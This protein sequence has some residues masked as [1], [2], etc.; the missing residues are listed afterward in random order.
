MYSK[1][2]IVVLYIHE[3]HIIKCVQFIFTILVF[4]QP[5][6]VIALNN[7]IVLFTCEG[8]ADD[9]E[10]IHD[11]NVNVNITCV[12]EIA[13]YSS[14]LCNISI[15][16]NTRSNGTSVQCI[17]KGRNVEIESEV[18][19]LTVLSGKTF[20]WRHCIFET[21]ITYIYKNNKKTF[22]I[23]MK[24]DVGMSKPKKHANKVGKLT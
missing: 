9:V 8:V 19:I 20:F 6:S 16:A 12:E 21:M 15:L 1:S 2:T 5:K 13:A 17:F 24:E 3:L 14:I 11:N 4:Q 22:S 10:V 18:A 7:T 23:K